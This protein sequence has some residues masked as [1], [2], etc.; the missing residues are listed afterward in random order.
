MR[1]LSF[2][3]EHE[4][5]DRPSFSVFGSPTRPAELFLGLL[6]DHVLRR[7]HPFC[8]VPGEP[9]WR[10]Q[11]QCLRPV[12][13]MARGFEC[14]VDGKYHLDTFSQSTSVHPA[15]NSRGDVLVEFLACIYMRPSSLANGAP[16]MHAIRPRLVCTAHM[17]WWQGVGSP[18]NLYEVIFP[19]PPVS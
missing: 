11:R 9:Q 2:E 8:V 5:G 14:L 15:C 18:A 13:A 10:P 16:T 7:T 3:D 12:D 4:A 6:G 19:D 17:T 1:T